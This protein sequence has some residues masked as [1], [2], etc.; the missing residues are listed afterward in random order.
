MI[1]QDAEVERILEKMVIRRI[2]G[3][4]FE[5]LFRLIREGFEKEIAIV[6]FDTRRLLRAA[7]LY[8]HFSAVLT[9]LDTLH[10]DF[11]VVLT[12]VSGDTLI[13]A[14]HLVP[15]GKGTWSID[16]VVVDKP[17]RGHGVYRRLM[18]EA[19]K[20][21]FEKHGK[22]IRQSVWSD[23]V[24]PL[25]VAAELKFETIERT[26]LLV[27]ELGGVSK[28]RFDKD[29]QVRSFKPNDKE[30]IDEICKS[31]EA[32]RL[33]AYKR[34]SEDHHGSFNHLV[35]RIVGSR[36]KRWVIEA[37]GKP[38]GYASI[39]Y[40]S[41]REAGYIE[42]FCVIQSNDSSRFERT[43][44]DTILAF[45]AT[46]NVSRVV[47]TFNEERKQTL[48]MCEQLGFKPVTTLY[49]LFKIIEQSSLE[50]PRICVVTETDL[51]ARQISGS[52]IN[53]L[54]ML[55]HFK[56]FGDV[57]IIYLQRER[58]STLYSSLTV[59]ILQILRSLFK[60]YR[61]YFTRSVLAS[62]ILT[63]LRPIGRKKTLVVHQAFSVPLPSSE[64]KYQGFGVIESFVRMVLFGFLEKR[65]LPRVDL[66]TIA[67]DDYAK[68]LVGI[69]VEPSRIHVV[70]FSVE[71]A[72]FNQPPKKE[73][74]PF[75][76]CYVGSFQSYHRLLPLIEAFDSICK[77]KE[78]LLLLLVG[79][80]PYRSTLEKEVE[81][82]GLTEKVRFMGQL[83]HSSLPSFLLG[84]DCLVSLIPKFGISISILEAAASEKAIIAFT[85]DDAYGR[86]FTPGEHIYLL[87]T[88]APDE[89]TRAIK[90]ISGN[91]C[92]KNNLAKGAREVAKR[93][94]CEQVVLLQLQDLFRK[95]CKDQP[96]RKVP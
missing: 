40:T 25:K 44:M 79:A 62:Y 90:T 18:N 54:K 26:I 87:N 84:V 12:A 88:S 89:I 86:F 60:P 31:I 3:K 50:N 35:D 73:T 91:P 56:K 95:I 96:L 7:R 28:T 45:F 43:L 59:F 4:D 13:G 27:L 71:D 42:H 38:V 58:Y 8:R 11:P 48:E 64:V 66:V 16:S 57:E 85:P 15:Y 81:H 49:E 69:G 94:F 76:L 63:S 41:S 52:I 22:G 1:S 51:G 21:V 9:L 68:A 53:D 93:H 75:T 47:A 74:P 19:V 70:H 5:Q 39:R 33:D 92:L 24:A 36:S 67:A 83:S 20:Y 30:Q 80:G 10:L 82:R 32:R 78:N 29:V 14:I 77:T 34:M 65:A 23:N 55:N 72:F 2:R 46:E 6:G 17:F 37:H 61:I